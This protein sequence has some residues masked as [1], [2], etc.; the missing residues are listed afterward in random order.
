[1]CKRRRK[2]QIPIGTYPTVISAGQ[3]KDKAVTRGYKDAFVRRQP[4]ILFGFP[5]LQNQVIQTDS[6]NFETYQTLKEE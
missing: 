5:G 3:I 6:F 2:I 4:E 1:L